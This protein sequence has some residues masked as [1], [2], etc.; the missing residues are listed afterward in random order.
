MWRARD[1]CA[2]NWSSTPGSPTARNLATTGFVRPANSIKGMF[3][4]QHEKLFAYQGQGRQIAIVPIELPHV[5]QILLAARPCDAAALPVLDHVFNWDYQDSFFRQR[6][7]NT[8][9]V[10]VACREHDRPL[11]LHEPGAGSGCHARFRCAAR[12]RG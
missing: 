10:T 5:E 9:V 8:T 12:S 2:L 6:R 7:A 1:A 11:F 3:L 4:P